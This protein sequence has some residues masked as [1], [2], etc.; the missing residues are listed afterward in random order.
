MLNI[1]QEIKTI[2]KETMSERDAELFT[3]KLTALLFP[4][5]KTQNMEDNLELQ[6]ILI[7]KWCEEKTTQRTIKCGFYGCGATFPIS[8]LEDTDFCPECEEPFDL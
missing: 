2:A 4:E 5:E 6:E 7:D 1:K 8:V 3:N